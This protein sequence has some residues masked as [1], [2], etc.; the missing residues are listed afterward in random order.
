MLPGPAL[1]LSYTTRGAVAVV[2]VVVV[3]GVVASRE[4]YLLNRRRCFEF[5]LFSL[6]RSF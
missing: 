3:V 1:F 2:V 5:I 4:T 6:S